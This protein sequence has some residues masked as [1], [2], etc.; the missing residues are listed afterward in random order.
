MAI[1]IVP[2]QD[3]L[4]RA[5]VGNGDY[6]YF[7]QLQL[8]NFIE[9]GGLQPHHRVLDV[10][11][12]VGRMAT[13]LLDYLDDRGSY[14]GFDVVV[15]S[16]EWC[17][18]N[19]TPRRPT[20]RFQVADVHNLMYRPDCPTPPKRYR[21]PYSDGEFDFVF[22]TSVFTHMLP[23][24]LDNYLWQ[25]RR[26]L[27]PQ[28]RCFA[29]FLLLNEESRQGIGAG[30][31]TFNF[32]H[33]LGP[34]SVQDSRRPENVV[35]YEESYVR[36]RLRRAGLTAVGWH[37]GNWSGRADARGGQDIVV[38]ERSPA[39]WSWLRQWFGPRPVKAA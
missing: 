30:R 18:A 15:E 29:T 38:I 35:G 39:R 36:Q 1:A 9:V 26:V 28:G 23:A 34:C 25:I 32:P 22:L 4:D 24:G 20:F 2:P 10:G 37:Y 11:C 21:F 7:G 19:V 6:I 31:A 17:Q 33:R 14:E 27:K 12:G 16:V 3:L 5:R 8:R 13:A